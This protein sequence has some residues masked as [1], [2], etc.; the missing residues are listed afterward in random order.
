MTNK[1]SELLLPCGN[2]SM[3]LAAIHNGANAIYV[4]MPGF[5]AR[6]RTHD[7]SFDELEEIIQT[8]HLYNVHVHVAFNILIFQNE[9]DEAVLTLKRVLKMGPDA[10]IV[11]D[12]GL[13]QII[14]ELA[15]NQVIHGSTQMTVTNHEA[16]NLLD[17]LDIKRFVLGR[18]NSLEEIKIIRDKTKKELEVFVHGALCVAYSGQCFTS[19]AIGG[20]SANRGQCAQ[21]CRYEYDLIVD[22]KTQDLK[23][24]K[25]L[26]SPKDLCGIKDIPKLVNLGIESFK[27]EGRLKSPEFVASVASSYRKAIDDFKNLDSDQAMKDMAITYSRG[28]YNG[29]MDGVAH[30]NLVDGTYANNRGIFVGEVFDVYKKIVK[31]KTDHEL[32]PG[33]G[34]LMAKGSELI[35]GQI[36]GIK[37]VRGLYEISFSKELDVSKVKKGFKVF[38]NSRDKLYKELK[39]SFTD[40]NSF[41]RLPISIQISGEAGKTLKLSAFEGMTKVMTETTLD[42]EKAQTR[43]LSE[44]S[45]FDVLKGLTHTAYYLESIKVDIEENVFI[46]NKELKQLKQKMVA[47]LNEK[48]LKRELIVHEDYSRPLLVESN[49]NDGQ[50]VILIRTFDQLESTVKLLMDNESY[51]AYLKY[52]VLDYE[53]GKD[54]VKSVKILKEN[55]IKSVIATTRILKPNEYH[56]FKLIERAN[57]DGLLIRNLGALNYF[58]D[59]TFDLYGDFSLNVTNSKTFNYL[60]GKGLNSIC[61]SYDMNNEQ[62]LGLLKHVDSSKVEI[63]AHQYMPEF[64]MEHCVFA[65]FLSKGQTFRDCGKP[66]EKHHVQLKDMYGNMH[67]IKADQECRNTMYS[68]KSMSAANLVPNWQ[69]LGVS[70]FRFEA[71]HESGTAYIDKIETYLKLI[72]KKF[73][74]EEVFDKIGKMESYGVSTGQLLNNK[75]YKDRKKNVR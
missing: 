73:T 9:L 21:S 74:T 70:T 3:A 53:F 22:G 45:L 54:F 68:A 66:C 7:H 41:K 10:L 27:V 30:Q 29:W 69:N 47:L 51:R 16:I 46:H 2:I 14:K 26:V 36:Y 4:G 6:G 71:L 62:L 52:I 39:K 67:E 75:E 65:A 1:N 34:V 64:H 28:F 63:T 11:Q 32:Y 60:I 43:G 50:L 61:V 37:K 12:L 5:N 23:D 58:K 20:R 48:R 56:N 25:Y 40:K 24:I 8:C 57:P 59:S 49:E 44:E 38:L 42:L 33:D 35:G 31:I 72:A 13:V 55:N 15:P 19:E 18:E 17:D